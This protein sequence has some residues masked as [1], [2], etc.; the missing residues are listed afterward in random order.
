MCICIATIHFGSKFSP[1][2]TTHHPHPLSLHP[3]AGLVLIYKWLGCCLNQSRF[4]PTLLT[5]INRLIPL[6]ILRVV[7]IY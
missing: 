4:V 1:L 6:Y 3:P 7:M 2:L 5:T